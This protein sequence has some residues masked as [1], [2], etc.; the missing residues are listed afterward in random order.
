MSAGDVT[1]M[2]VGWHLRVG[3]YSVVDDMRMY[4]QQQVQNKHSSSLSIRYLR[5]APLLQTYQSTALN[6]KLLSLDDLK[7]SVPHLT[8]L[9]QFPSPASL[10]SAYL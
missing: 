4:P 1:A 8:C 6:T 7:E 3:R 9:Q 10:P 5:C 2:T